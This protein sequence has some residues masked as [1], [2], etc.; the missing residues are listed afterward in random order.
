MLADNPA[1]ATEGAQ[2]AALMTEWDQIVQADWRTIARQMCQPRF[3]FDGR[4]ALEPAA[5]ERLGFEYRGVG[6]NGAMDCHVSVMRNDAGAV[7]G[8]DG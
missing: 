6:R 7:T 2:A 8:E 1:K 3:L 5:M 4:N